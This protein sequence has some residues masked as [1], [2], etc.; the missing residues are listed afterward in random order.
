MCADSGSDLLK[1]AQT[2][3]FPFYRFPGTFIVILIKEMLTEKS[4]NF[5]VELKNPECSAV[6]WYSLYQPT[7]VITFYVR[8][9]YRFIHC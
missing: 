9:R 8:A 3:P 6:K 2:V 1:G 4:S 7:G 5:V